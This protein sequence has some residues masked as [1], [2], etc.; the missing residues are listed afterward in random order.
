MGR[1]GDKKRMRA[2]KQSMKDVTMNVTNKKIFGDQPRK[3]GS[4]KKNNETYHQF[5][6]RSAWPEMGRVRR[7]ISAC[8]S[9][10]PQ[11]DLQ[12]IINRL[13]S[14]NDVEFRSAT[15][16]LFL[17][18]ALLR[19]GCQ[20]TPH[21]ELNNGSAKRPDFLV[22]DSGGMEFYL[23]AVLATQNNN[24]DEGATARKGVVMDKLAA[25]PHENF[26]IIIEDDGVPASAPSGKALTAKIHKFLN[27]LDPDDV[28]KT[29]NQSG[30]DAVDYI[31]WEHD[32]W[33]VKVIPVPLKPERRGKSKSLIGAGPIEG[34][35]IDDWSPI[36]KAVKSKGGRYGD[37]NAPLIVAVNMN[38]FRLD[39]IDEVQA[40]YGQEEFVTTVGSGGGFDFQ[41]A[42]N[43]A[44]IGPNG[45]QY[46][47]VSAA[48]IFNDLHASSIASR[49][50][51]LYINPWGKHAAPNSMT[52]F[53]HVTLERTKL[54]RSDGLSFRELFKLNEG[55][56]EKGQNK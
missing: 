35:W 44:W 17:H 8:A 53:P 56:P 30:F 10:Y 46:T 50:N 42:P 13:T 12:E 55:W 24:V 22:R 1:I 54:K 14:G 2:F 11:D 27:T 29:I 32:G 28:Q 52:T 48:W 41:R 40:L 15:F 7:L 16:E 31:E 47:R 5:Y 36:R 38:S 49:K 39:P 6:S 37:L 18:E 43:G 25:S 19:R 34:G 33:K 26:M 20:L 23:E 45:P 21:P 51:T 4:P 3:D 9:N